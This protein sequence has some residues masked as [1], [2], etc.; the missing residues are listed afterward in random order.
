MTLAYCQQSAL[1]HHI[2]KL[3][4]ESNSICAMLSKRSLLE[5]VKLDLVESWKLFSVALLSPTLK[6]VKLDLG[7][8]L[9]NTCPMIKYCNVSSVVEYLRASAFVGK[10][11][12]YR[13]GSKVTNAV[14]LCLLDKHSRPFLLLVGFGKHY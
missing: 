14:L 12:R 5:S 13:R 10:L 6:A 1:Q 9:E 4:W 2:H 11:Y 3:Q 8:I 7:Q